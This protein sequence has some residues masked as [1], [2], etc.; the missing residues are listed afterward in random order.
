MNWERMSLGL[1]TLV[2]SIAPNQVQICQ[3]LD[4]AGFIKYCGDAKNHNVESWVRNLTDWMETP[5]KIMNQMAQ[6]GYDLVDGKGA[7]RVVEA[8]SEL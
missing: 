4:Q 3:D 2:V 1:P 5:C 6:K 8:L 7:S